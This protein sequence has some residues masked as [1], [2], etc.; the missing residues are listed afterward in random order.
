[1]QRRQFLTNS[2][3]A[4]GGAIATRSLLLQHLPV[5]TS[6]NQGP[7]W[8]F[9]PVVGDGKWIWREPPKSDRGYLEP[10]SYEVSIGMELNGVSNTCA[11]MAATPVPMSHPEQ[12]VLEVS[13]EKIGCEAV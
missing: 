5:I 9:E 10:R 2:V 3:W 1:M 4:A 6:Y 8:S 11:A 13:I 12:Q 7:I